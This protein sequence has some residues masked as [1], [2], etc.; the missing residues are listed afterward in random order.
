MRSCIGGIAGKSVVGLLVA[1]VGL[2]IA[3]RGD[4]LPQIYEVYGTPGNT[5]TLPTSGVQVTYD[6]GLAGSALN[7]PNQGGEASLAGWTELGASPSA[8]YA[9]PGT[10][11]AGAVTYQDYVYAAITFSQAVVLTG[12]FLV[13]DVDWLQVVSVFGMNGTSLVEADST[14]VGSQLGEY[15]DSV[16]WTNQLPG[17]SLA[18]NVVDAVVAPSSGGTE[19]NL[20]YRVTYNFVDAEV[21]QLYFV[22]AE[23]GSGSLT[24]AGGALVQLDF[25]SAG[26]GVSAAGGSAA[27]GGPGHPG[28]QGTPEPGCASLLLV[29]LSALSLRRRRR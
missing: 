5:Y 23:D 9:D 3:A 2:S 25:S 20:A 12:D 29:A 19:T 27:A 11:N 7:H 17:Q 13:T 28:T 21:T 15:A 8:S 26:A 6:I 22:F 14:V 24:G 18:N 4:D 10:F 16:T 1:L